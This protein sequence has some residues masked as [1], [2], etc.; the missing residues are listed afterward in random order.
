MRTIVRVPC[1]AWYPRAI[2]NLYSVVGIRN[3]ASFDMLFKQSRTSPRVMRWLTSTRILIAFESDTIPTCTKNTSAEDGSL[4]L[5][6]LV[7]GIVM[8]DVVEC[9]SAA[10]MC[11]SVWS[12][13][14]KPACLGTP[15]PGLILHIPPR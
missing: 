1:A 6:G 3:R 4:N 11:A 8:W 9:I 13:Q 2:H 15:I 12:R 7:F 10:Q 5:I 14:Q